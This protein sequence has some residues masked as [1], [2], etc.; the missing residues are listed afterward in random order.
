VST[1]AR[2]NS[3]AAWS[4]SPA[5]HP[6][7][8]AA[9]SQSQIPGLDAIRAFAV[10]LVIVFHMGYDVDGG[11]GVLIFF[12]LSGFLITWL[13]LKEW[14]KS[15]R[16]DLKKF[17]IRRSL[18]IFPAFYVYWVF[19]IAYLTVTKKVIDWPHAISSLFYLA[20]YYHIFT[21]H[22]ANAFS[23]TWSLSVE[24]QFY[25]LWPL[26][27]LV[28]AKNLPKAVRF[29]AF[30]IVAVCAYRTFIFAMG[31]QRTWIYEGLDT[32][33][34]SLLAGCLL[35]IALHKKVWVG[36][37]NWLCDSS[38]KVC[39]TLLVLGYFVFSNQENGWFANGPFF[40]LMSIASAFL[41]V[42]V[43]A[44]AGS[45]RVWQWLNW[46]WLT[47]LGRISYSSYLY[48]QIL[49]HI[50]D[51]FLPPG[52]LVSQAVSY[53]AIIAVASAS[54]WLVEKPILKIK[55]RFK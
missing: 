34:D 33:A 23:H 30:A 17:Y 9:L 45:D 27:F 35:A 26:S 8:N 21:D 11:L 28:L 14:A 25:L 50:G 39:V 29:C 16:I 47:Y 32:R 38:W 53:A 12:T 46:P 4:S 19:M 2:G 31:A 40:T 44:A 55:D 5:L 3:E 18:R 49:H 41:I 24:E 51:R 22:P 15:G 42:Q 48:Q 36:L 1:S 54:Y 20:N 10:L 52:S 13:L 43:I 7:L 6:K 37:W